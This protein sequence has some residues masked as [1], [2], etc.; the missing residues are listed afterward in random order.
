M[1][2]VEAAQNFNESMYVNLFDHGQKIG[3]WLRVGN[4][5]NEGHAEMSCCLFLPGGRVGFMYQR[6]ALRH[7]QNFDAAGMKFE[8]VEPFRTLRAT[9]KGMLCV[10]DQPQQMEDPHKAFRENPIRHC[11][12]SF[13]FRGIAPPFGGEPVDASR[14]PAGAP[15][16]P[17]RSQRRPHP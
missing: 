3:G 6:P 14:K 15:C 12:L 9:Y 11:E 1:H 7:N 8:V 13:E 10:L 2:P 17:R 5:P 16:L 4:R